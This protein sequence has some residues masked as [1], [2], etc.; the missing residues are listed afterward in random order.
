MAPMPG[1]VKSI[2][3]SSGDEV[4]QALDKLQW[5]S[6]VLVACHPVWPPAF[7]MELLVISFP[8]FCLC[9]LVCLPITPQ[10]EAGQEVVVLEAM[11][12]QMPLCA[13]KTGKVP[14]PCSPIWFPTDLVPRYI[15]ALT[16][17]SC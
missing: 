10:V 2:G 9:L 8:V 13:P 16:T 4:G 15:H 11:K 1:V 6:V 12:L 7:S 5:R 3:C 14:P 17:D